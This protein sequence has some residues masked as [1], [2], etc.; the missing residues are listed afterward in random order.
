MVHALDIRTRFPGL[1]VHP[2][3]RSESEMDSRLRREVCDTRLKYQLRDK[4][5]SAYGSATIIDA[6]DNDVREQLSSLL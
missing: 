4:N 2:R 5:T 6:L 1:L 3:L